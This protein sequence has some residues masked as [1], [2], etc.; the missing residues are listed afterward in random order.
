MKGF[1]EEPLANKQ[2]EESILRVITVD[3]FQSEFCPSCDDGT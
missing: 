1:L 3:D 2:V